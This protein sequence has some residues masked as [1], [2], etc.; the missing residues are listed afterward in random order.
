MKKPAP[1]KSRVQPR[2][3]LLPKPAVVARLAERHRHEQAP[4]RREHAPELTQRGLAA[5]RVDG[6]AA[7]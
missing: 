2:D 5:R 3:V 7:P 6:A 1:V 4:V